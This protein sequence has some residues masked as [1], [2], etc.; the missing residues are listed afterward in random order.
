M[1]DTYHCPLPESHTFSHISSRHY[2]VTLSPPTTL[3]SAKKCQNWKQWR[4]RK[5]VCSWGARACRDCEWVWDCSHSSHTSMGGRNTGAATPRRSLRHTTDQRNQNLQ[6]HKQGGMHK[7]LDTKQA[8]GTKT[9]R[10]TSREGCTST[11][12]RN[13]P[14]D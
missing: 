2:H 12:T 8:S 10:S 14:V 11:W 4:I 6:A 7:H 3:R 13:R 1:T 5:L 9:C